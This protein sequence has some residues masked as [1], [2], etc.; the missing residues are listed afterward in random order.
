MIPVFQLLQAERKLRSR[1][2]ITALGGLGSE[3]N[4][5]S[6]RKAAL[7]DLGQENNDPPLRELWGRRRKTNVQIL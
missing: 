2:R 3:L 7:A 1:S 4:D 6:C 5:L